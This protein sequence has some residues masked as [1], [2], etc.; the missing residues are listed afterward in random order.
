MSD[1][2]TLGLQE[3]ATAE[4][5]RAA[6]KS[7]VQTHHPDKGGDVDVFQKI[8]KAYKRLSKRKCNQCG[9]T[10]KVVVR[11]GAFKKTEDCPIC[12][13]KHGQ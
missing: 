9:G 5:I 1:Y 10:G 11:N 4:E 6:Y 2:E 3:G 12:W 8:V 13:R 7:K